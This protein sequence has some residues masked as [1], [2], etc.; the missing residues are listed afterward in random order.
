[1]LCAMAATAATSG[2]EAASDIAAVGTCTSDMASIPKVSMSAVCGYLCVE[3]DGHI[4]IN[5]YLLF[6]SLI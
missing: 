4:G 6:F 1:M 5:N 2:T 3:G